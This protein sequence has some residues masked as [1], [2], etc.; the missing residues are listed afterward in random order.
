VSTRRLYRCRSDRKI[1]GVAAG[2]AEYLELDPT[3]VRVAWILS[4]FIGGFTILLY[5]ILAFIIPLEPVD[6]PAPGYGAGPQFGADGPAPEP[7][8][9]MPATAPTG[10]E[11]FAPNPH[12]AAAASVGHI[13]GHV[14]DGH[15]ARGRSGGA[16]IV[17]GV[18]LVVFG[19]IALAGQLFP[20]WVASSALGPAFVLALGVALLAGAAR[21]PAVEE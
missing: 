7:G 11:G 13:H 12:W 3:V 2:M 20:G 18:L 6:M 8:A 1:A 4:A 15:R 14:S 21:R 10:S 16:G 9:D 5:I 17:F 19:A